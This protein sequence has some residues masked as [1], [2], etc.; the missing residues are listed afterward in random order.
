MYNY[1]LLRLN[2]CN[3]SVSQA[4]VG[5]SASYD[6]L[7]DLFECIENFLGR[8]RIYIE[9]PFSPSMCGIFTKVIVEV[10]SVLSLATKQ[11]KEGRLSEIFRIYISI[12][13]LLMIL[14]QRCL[15]RNC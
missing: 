13:S 5:V 15:R 10:L 8:L 2:L 14:S 11:I 6:A 9:I 7:I 1:P 12:Y 4:A 3:I